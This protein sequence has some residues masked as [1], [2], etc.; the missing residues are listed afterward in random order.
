MNQYWEKYKNRNKSQEHLN[1]PYDKYESNPVLEH[2]S[3]LQSQINSLED[4]FLDLQCKV[5]SRTAYEGHF[6]SPSIEKPEKFQ[7]TFRFFDERISK[8]EQNSQFFKYE[9]L[10]MDLIK[11]LNLTESRINDFINT[12]LA[13]F[14]RKLK[15]FNDKNRKNTVRFEDE[16][17]EGKIDPEWQKKIEKIVVICAEKIKS[18]EEK[19][20][21]DQSIEFQKQKKIQLKINKRLEEL[22]DFSKRICRKLISLE[23][24]SNL[25][26]PLSKHQ[27]NDSNLSFTQK[28]LQ[29]A[30]S[31][32]KKSTEE[33]PRPKSRSTSPTGKDL[34]SK[35]D[36]NK[37]EKL[38]K[39]L[40]DF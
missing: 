25:S 8:L 31:K 16:S 30:D 34:K 17:N 9:N 15:E 29:Q 39:E 37:L 6:S 19:P 10:R 21:N 20:N 11:E 33:K 24:S 28:K 38:F 5:S 36:Q 26:S 40:K 27:K 7:E 1:Q 12:E 2:I 35:K 18:F 13:T 32:P 22:E 14:H 4:K 3:H 23:S